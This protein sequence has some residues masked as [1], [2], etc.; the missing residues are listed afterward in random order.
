[1]GNGKA[2]RAVIEATG[3]CGAG[4]VLCKNLGFVGQAGMDTWSGDGG[5]EGAKNLRAAEAVIGEGE[6]NLR[7][8]EK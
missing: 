5:G 1:V 2:N 8:W 4:V 7:L 3:G 6:I